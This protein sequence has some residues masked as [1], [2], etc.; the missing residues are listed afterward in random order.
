MR[1]L[2]IL[3]AGILIL[4]AVAVPAAAVYYLV[5]TQSGF[6]FIV[7]RIP[8][9]VAGVGIEI[10]NAG[11]TVAR[12]IHVEQLDIDHHLVHLTFKNIRARVELTPLLL[13]TIRT[14]G[15]S[16]E[17]ATVEIKRRKKPPIKS[18][19]FFLPRWL[20]ISADH[21]RIGSLNLAVYNGAHLEATDLY[22]SGIARHRKVRFYE[23]GMQMGTLRVDGS[24]QMFAEDPLRF[25]MQTKINWTP[26]DQPAWSVDAV[27]KGDLNILGVTAHTLAPFRSD[28]TGQALNLTGQWHWQGNAIV[29]DLDVTAWGGNKILG[30]LSGQVALKGNNNGFAAHGPL[31][32]AGLKVGTFDTE[33]EGAYS[34]HVLWAKHIGITHHASGAHVS[35]GGT[36][37]VV[38]NGPRLD[39]RGTWHDFRWPLTAKI[40]PFHSSSGE[41]TLGGTWPYAVHATGV[42]QARDLPPM[43][44]TIDGS[45]AKDRFT[46]TKGDV[47]LYGGHATLSGE[48]IWAPGDSW[49]FAGHVSD[50]NPA[51]I[52]TDLPGKLSFNIA[53]QGQGFDGNGDFS[54]DVHDI[55]GRL[56]GVPASGGGRVLR[57]GTTW[58]FD[59]LRVGLGATNL[60][61]DGHLN[62][63]FDLRFALTA[64]DLSLLAPDS[65]GQLEGNGTI[66]GTLR[67]P[68]IA[69]NIHGNGIQHEGITVQDI[70]ADIDFDPNPQYESKVDARIHNFVYKERKLDNLTFKLNGRSSNYEVRLDAK[71]LGMSMAAMANGPFNNGAW[72]GQLRS[73]D[74][75]GTESLRLKLERPGG[76][77]VS[78][79]EVRAD[80]MCVV[81]QPG[82]MCADGE[83][84]PGQWNATFNA[85][86]MPLATFTAGLTHAVDYSGQIN[87]L[88][89]FSG[90]GQEPP[91]GTVRIDLT[92][93][94]LSHKLSSGRIDHSKIGSGFITVN[95]NRAALSGEVRLESGDVGTIKGTLVA[96]RTADNWQAMPVQGELH[97]HTDQ[98]GLVTLYV[99]DI[100]RASGHLDG[101]MKIAGTLGTPLV[102]GNLK[103]S[104]GEIDYYQVNMG[105]R[106]LAF[107]AKLTDN[108]VDFK[109]STRI[110][111][112]IA[113]ASGRLEWRN[114]LPYGKVNVEG[115]NLRVTDVPEAQIDASPK[116]E[117]NINGR[118][119]EVV[120]AV[121]VPYAKIAPADLTGA[122]RSSSD[123]VIV[124]QEET[125]PS[126]RF[127]VVSTIALSLADHVSIDT[128]GL[129]GRLTGNIT[130]RSGY[131]EVT[132]ATGELNIEQGKYSAYARKLDIQR[133]RLI[134]TG[135]PIGNPGIDIRAIKEFPDVTAGVNVRGTLLQPRLSFFS[136][137]S[138]TQSQ[139]VSLILAGGSLES[140]QN[141]QPG[142]GNEMLAQGGA[143]LAQQLGSHVGIEDVSIE[144]DLTN[145]TSLV[146]GRYLSPRLYVSYGIALTQQLNVLKLRYS[147]G[148]RWTMKTE[149]GTATG[150]DLVYT[151]QR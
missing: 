60:A 133:G 55:S 13:Q 22:A 1:R 138:L 56:R 87:F 34:N 92:D 113:N 64:K 82:S 141:R 77:L 135:G 67:E 125:D 47:D 84:N 122:V 3:I 124:G 8:H 5:F 116:L 76:I 100:D 62:D 52:R 142:A 78:A 146:L 132:S 17:S 12:G 40:V 134:F 106:Q 123:E 148:D 9:Q 94:E 121:K 136:D 4:I 128:T 81:G 6:E 131:D 25:D 126:K 7:S 104:D 28:F 114:S 105:L 130:V 61:M 33:F 65:R 46:F 99:P 10:V 119:I 140:A 118:R 38:K 103:I 48:T 89:R 75:V 117:F 44:T 54:V 74:I 79:D 36:I 16:I 112:G 120:G 144:Q 110:G 139:I 29:H 97:A 11:G 53:T 143:I 21:T 86:Q 27:S 73:M 23:V 85:K 149:V 32:S 80:W 43:P 57:T 15:A 24:G 90:A 70:D 20:I 107:D 111:S 58:Q 91:Q 102:D 39:L 68:T 31:D 66:R 145:E 72:Q 50:V 109:G 101:D 2:L 41:F 51:L 37:E 108:G 96:Q 35:S 45:L 71:A 150:A 59:K 129:T 69:A 19:P 42:A 83:W 30:L 147:L 18:T 26:Q 63:T 137:P 93:A 49:A 98:L 88:A 14:K 95:A 127:E 115:T 151:I